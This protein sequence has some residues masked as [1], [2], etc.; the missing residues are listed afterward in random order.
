MENAMVVALGVGLGIGVPAVPRMTIFL[1]ILF[2]IDR[3]ALIPFIRW[4]RVER[5]S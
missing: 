1:N 4:S 2:N 5:N 3:N